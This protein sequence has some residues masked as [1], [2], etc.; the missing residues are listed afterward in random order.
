MNFALNGTTFK[1]VPV[2]AAPFIVRRV[3]LRCLRLKNLEA[4]TSHIPYQNHCPQMW[5]LLRGFLNTGIPDLQNLPACF[6]DVGK[7]VFVSEGENWRISPG[8]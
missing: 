6:L 3:K 5:I 2:V 1:V 7:R 8:Y 4:K